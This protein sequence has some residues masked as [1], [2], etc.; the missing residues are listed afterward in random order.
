M[1]D[2]KTWSRIFEFQELQGIALLAEELFASE[3]GH[4]FIVI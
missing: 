1:A 4:G 3:E 2:S